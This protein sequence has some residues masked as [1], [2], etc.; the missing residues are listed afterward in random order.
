MTKKV[1]SLARA[2]LLALLLAA[3]ALNWRSS[4]ELAGDSAPAAAGQRA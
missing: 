4:P 2:A 3:P 1:R